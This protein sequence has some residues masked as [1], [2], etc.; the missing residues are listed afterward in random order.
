[1]NAALPN[2]NSPQLLTRLLEL[3]ARGVRSTRG[4]QEALAVE[5]RTVQYYERAAEWLGML[6]TDGGCTLT[7]LGLEY[8]Y[9]GR[10]R[11][12]VYAAAVRANP[13]AASV[14]EQSGD[15]LPTLDEV[16]RAVARA[17]PD[18]APATVRRR[19]SA[20]RALIAP[21]LGRR[22]RA[23]SHEDAGR[24]LALPLTPRATAPAPRLRPAGGAEY[25]PDV[26]RFVYAAL[27]NHGELTLG[28]I[29]ALL[30]RAGADGAPVGGYVDLALARGDA[31]RL[32]ERLV[33]TADGA[34]RRDLATSTASIILSDPGYRSWL[35]D[36][37]LP[38]DRSAAVRRERVRA[39]YRHWD[40]RLVGRTVDPTELPR[41]ISR[42]LLDRPLG[43]F[44]IAG[45]SL[46]DLEPVEEPFLDVA[47]RPGLALVLPP[48]LAALQGGV[49]AVN[50]L[51]QRA[52]QGRDVEPPDLSVRPL[53]F[54]GGLVHPGE[55]LP[56]SVPDARSLRL[57]L[58]MHAPYPAMVGA[59]LLLHRQRPDLALVR[60]DDGW[61]IRRGK[62]RLGGLL[63]VLDRFATARGH[64]VARGPDGLTATD[65]V[66]LLEA[67]GVACVAGRV[68]VLDEGLFVK[69]RSE[70]EEIELHD[71]L[72]PLAEA[73]EG[74]LDAAP[75]EA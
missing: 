20:V 55:P 18:L 63:E 54:H 12:R 40:R 22:G 2:A 34:A 41:A 7:P 74:W 28:R 57:R 13:L 42:I 61:A 56:R 17:E 36:G 32:D 53:L 3:V 26:Y 67:V 21:A 6:D 35:A 50:R 68:A 60:A 14:L 64:V 59:L 29:R 27:L 24:Q 31:R 5:A 9:A 30:D 49:A 19:A 48:S 72:L 45:R 23:R 8:V 43:S 69:L 15:R 33:L 16:Q 46:P 65:L 10:D 70:A 75:E 39:R 66:T 62:R 25:D 1:M 44:P 11:P 52:R 37:L 47:D 38:D 73:L 71:R 4:L 51:L 58:L